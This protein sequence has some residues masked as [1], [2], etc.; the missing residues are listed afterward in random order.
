M[1]CKYALAMDGNVVI[2]RWTGTITYDELMTHKT[3]QLG[4]PSIKANASVLS[5][6]TR[7]VI[8]IPLG[9]IDQL[10]EIDNHADRSSKISRYAFLLNPDVYDRAQRFADRVSQS[11]KR[12]LIFNRLD[13]ACK[14][15]GLDPLKARELIDGMDG[16]GAR[17]GLES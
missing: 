9:A 17:H 3:Q 11:G 6:C 5:D 1:P 10:S 2:E 4:D 7:A 15:L 16:Q 8:E 14:W 12:V 13:A